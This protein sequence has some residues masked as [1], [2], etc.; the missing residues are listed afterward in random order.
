M[1]HYV[2]EF[3]A[4]VR[5]QWKVVDRV[6]SKETAHENV[7]QY[8]KHVRRSDEMDGMEYRIRKVKGNLNDKV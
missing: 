1:A 8:S 4:T 7:K 3:R 5:K 6:A 2:V